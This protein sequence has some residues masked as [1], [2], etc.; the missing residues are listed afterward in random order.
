MARVSHSDVMSL[1]DAAQAWNWTL[2]IPSLPGG[3]GLSVSQGLTIKCKTTAIPTSKIA[4]VKIDLAG[5]S[6]QEAGPAQYDHAFTTQFLETVDFET[7][8]AFRA[9]RDHMRSWKN[10]TGTDSSSYK[11][12]LELD[13]FDNAPNV[14]MSMAL[15]GAFPTEIQEI[16][17]DGASTEALFIQVTWSFDHLDDGSTY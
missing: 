12:K 9:W 17:L 3:S 13:L 4:A 1:P 10:N 11:R 8:R 14:G 16:Q 7:V 15:V 6:K 5:V 2:F